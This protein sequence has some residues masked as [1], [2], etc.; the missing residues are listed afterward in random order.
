MINDPLG[1]MSISA[2]GIIKRDEIVFE[3]ALE[4]Y[5]IP[6]AMVLSGGYQLANAPV[7]ADSIQNLMNKFGLNVWLNL[8][9]YIQS[10]SNFSIT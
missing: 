2:E 6:I 4:K 10:L 8:L 1:G 5:K 3:F 9:K 7:I